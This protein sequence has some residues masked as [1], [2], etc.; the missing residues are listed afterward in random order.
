MAPKDPA[1]LFFSLTRAANQWHRQIDTAVR[2]LGLTAASCRLLTSIHE[3]PSGVRQKDVAKA[4]GVETS[5]LVRLL[6]SL[7]KSGLVQRRVG[8]DRRSNHLHL[9]NSGRVMAVRVKQLIDALH[10]RILMSIET[11]D[12]AACERT[13]VTLSDVLK[14]QQ[15]RAEAG[16]AN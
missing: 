7:E 12:K 10:R 16:A 4:I 5:S 6:D 13:F 1:R 9:T 15:D 14:K 2:D 3:L 8:K 11:M